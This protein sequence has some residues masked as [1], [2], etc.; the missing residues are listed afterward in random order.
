MLRV[1]V[2]RSPALLF[3]TGI[4]VR[5]YFFVTLFHVTSVQR[6]WDTGYE[7]CHIAASI[8]SGQGFS[9]PFG[10]PTGPTA[11]VPPLY[12]G[13]LAI[14]FKVFGTSTTAAACTMLFLDALFAALTAVN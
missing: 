12:V 8:V 9:S 11:W 4:L 14:V 5:V 6:V 13:I 2:F 3:A 10:V 1:R 7:A